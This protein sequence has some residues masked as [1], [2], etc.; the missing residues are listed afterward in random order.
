MEK[1]ALGLSFRVWGLGLKV[2]GLGMWGAV[3]FV[4]RLFLFAA[5]AFMPSG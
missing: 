3:F 1:K 4:G 5:T 2:E